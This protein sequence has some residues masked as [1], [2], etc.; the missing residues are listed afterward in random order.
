MATKARDK[1]T[2]SKEE[3]DTPEG[4]AVALGEQD[5]AA[6]LTL[7]GVVDIFEANTL[8]G[9]ARRALAASRPVR[10]DLA[11]AVRLDL[12]AWQV[13]CA[14]GCEV[15]AAGLDFSLDA[16]PPALARTMTDSG[17]AP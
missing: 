1:K 9:A 8:L 4:A 14:L 2:V 15:R 13:V 7:C 12:S 5:G 3:K 6:V 17:L 10:L 16:V 11:R